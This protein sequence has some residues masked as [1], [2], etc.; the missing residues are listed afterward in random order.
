MSTHNVRFLWEIRKNWGAS[1]VHPQ[2]TFSLR[3]KK[4]WGASNEHPQR[5][6]SLRNKKNIDLIIWILF[7]ARAMKSFGQDR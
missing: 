3:N 5:T 4:N 6:F 2:H 1:N 7:L